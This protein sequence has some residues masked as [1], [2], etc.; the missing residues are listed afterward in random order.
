MAERPPLPPEVIERLRTIGLRIDRGGRMWHQGDEVTHPGLRRAILRWLDHAPDGRPIVRLDDERYAYVE[1]DD[2]PLRVVAVRWDDDAPRIFLDDGT[3]E[4][5]DL[6]TLAVDA[7][8]RLRCRARGGRLAARFT[9][10]AQHSLLARADEKR[11]QVGLAAVGRF[12]PLGATSDDGAGTD[13]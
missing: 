3:D 10:T 1:L 9:T 13:T 12:W 5:L 8:D 7:D 4:P 6:A 2:T 11:G